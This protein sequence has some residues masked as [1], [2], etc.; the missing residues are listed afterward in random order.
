M[1]PSPLARNRPPADRLSPTAERVEA[2]DAD[3]DDVLEALNDA[4]CR[5]ILEATGETALSATELADACDI[6]SSTTYRKLDFLTDI[7]LLEER[8]RID[9]GGS[10]TCEYHR[11]LEEVVIAADGHGTLQLWIRMRE[12]EQHHRIEMPGSV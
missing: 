8:I 5:E 4:G 7:G 10:N 9:P 1:T 3:A 11:R 12:P 2:V 6:P